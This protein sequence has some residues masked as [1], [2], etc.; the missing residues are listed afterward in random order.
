MA[1]N[2]P[3]SQTDE[4]SEDIV[5]FPS[6]SLISTVQR[7]LGQIDEML[8]DF[9]IVPFPSLISIVQPLLGQIDERLE[10]F[11]SVPSFP[12]FYSTAFT[13]PD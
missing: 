1:V 13:W 8:Q 12:Y 4:M 9:V 7:L 3:L 6:P 11:V 5:I 2:I 10:D